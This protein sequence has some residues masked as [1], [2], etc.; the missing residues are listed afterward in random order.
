MVGNIFYIET[1][2]LTFLFYIPRPNA[3]VAF[4]NDPNI[5]E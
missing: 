2:L 3:L 5:V 4:L 1:S